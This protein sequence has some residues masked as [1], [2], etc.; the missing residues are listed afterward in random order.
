MTRG[1]KAAY[2]EW[3]TAELIVAYSE[4][5][6][7]TPPRT[8]TD[9]ESAFEQ[10]GNLISVRD[11]DEL[12]DYIT[13]DFDSLASKTSP[14]S[15]ATSESVFGRNCLCLKINVVPVD[16]LLQTYYQTGEVDAKLKVSHLEVCNPRQ[17]STGE[18]SP[19]D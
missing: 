18:R 12:R 16:H 4:C 5:H 11:I 19:K 9:L 3:G 2:L 7:Q 13:I 8:W 15:V 17:E 10:Q 14:F 1:I 6:D